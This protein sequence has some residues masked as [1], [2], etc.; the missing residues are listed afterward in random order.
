[1]SL[2]QIRQSMREA[3]VADR[4]AIERLIAYAALDDAARAS[5]GKDAERLVEKVRSGLS[6]GMLESFLSEYSLSTTEGI[7]LMCLAEALLRVPDTGT[8]DDLIEDKIASARWLEHFD[9]ANPLLVNV[10]TLA[11]TLT[12]ELLK[13]AGSGIAG[14]VRCFVQ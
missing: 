8:M 1:M 12:G 10:S 6:A 5:I 3:L 13:D 7:A 9:A 11:L 14:T 2:E 4:A